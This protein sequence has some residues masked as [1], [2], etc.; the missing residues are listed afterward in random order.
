[1]ELLSMAHMYHVRDLEM[2]CIQRVKETISDD[3][4]MDVWM[5]GERCKMETLCSI[6]IEHLVERTSGKT[7]HDVPGFDEVFQD[8]DK[9]LKDL[10]NKLTEKNSHLQEEIL[11]L[12][13]KCKHHV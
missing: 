10:L 3:N 9:P 8:H 12:K 2:D 5:E 7:L 1:M 11:Q 4:V 13:E 6:A